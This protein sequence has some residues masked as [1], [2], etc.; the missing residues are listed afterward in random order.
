MRSFFE[1]AESK[2]V[3]PRPGLGPAMNRYVWAV[4]I[5]RVLN[6]EHTTHIYAPNKALVDFSSPEDEVNADWACQ[7]GNC[8]IKTTGIYWDS[9]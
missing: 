3:H 6:G 8:C 4:Y 7:F 1:A 5:H 9:S 2:A